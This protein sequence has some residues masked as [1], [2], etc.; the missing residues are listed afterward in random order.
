M[1]QDTLSALLKQVPIID[2][3]I[4]YEDGYAHGFVARLNLAQERRTLVCEVL[5]NGQPRF[6]H[7][8]TL[9]LQERVNQTGKPAIPVLIAPYFSPESQAICQAKHISFLDLEG[10]CR[11]VFDQV[12]IERRVPTKPSTQKRD[13]KSLFTPKSAQVLRVM[14]RDPSRSWRIAELAQ[15][16]AVSVGQVSNVRH[17]LINKDWAASNEDGL[18][19]KKPDALLDAWRDAYDPSTI[20][21]LG[22]Y[23]TL[24]GPAFYDAIKAAFEYMKCNSDGGCALFGSLSAARWQAPYV[25]MEHQ[26]FFYAND[27]G[28]EILTQY[29]N[30]TPAAKGEN[31]VITCLDDDDGILKDADEPAP[32][33]MC[34]SLIQTYLDLSSG[35][36]RYQE[37]A[38]HLRREKIIWPK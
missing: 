25:R 26:S 12:F 36:E 14:L 24:H 8:A 15:Q 33:I 19:L 2:P 17:A 1:A 28:L 4:I 38:E 32:G 21:R 30:L 27:R 11:M 10:N 13:L 9:L 6:V 29:L 23:T 5:V 22:F 37:A 34:T 16:S 3:V 7:I 35:G 31:V 20:K 18:S